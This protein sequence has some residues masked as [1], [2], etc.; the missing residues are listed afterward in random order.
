MKSLAAQLEIR[1][2]LLIL[3]ISRGKEISSHFVLDWTVSALALY[4]ELLK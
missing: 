2:G 1:R 4:L 3:L